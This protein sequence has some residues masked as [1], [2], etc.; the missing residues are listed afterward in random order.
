M[1]ALAEKVTGI[2]ELEPALERAKQADRTYAVATDT[3]PVPTTQEGVAWRAWPGGTL[4]CRRYRHA[5]KTL[6]RVPHM[7]APGRRR[8]G[9]ERR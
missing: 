7:S 4:P 1:G 5:S 2:G 3:D 9:A 8:R 6:M